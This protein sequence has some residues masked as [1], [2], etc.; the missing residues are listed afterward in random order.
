MWAVGLQKELKKA[1]KTFS[2]LELTTSDMADFGSVLKT[3]G[4]NLVI[5]NTDKFAFVSPFLNSLRTA[6]TQYD[7]LLFEQYSW[8]NQN[9]KMPEGIYI[10][11]F[12]FNVNQDKL[13][14]YN[15]FVYEL[16][17]EKFK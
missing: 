4:K 12:I 7:L 3:D 13:N 5:F 1:N 8:K 11:P 14:A 6:A 10:S 17:W 16:L 9:E 2:K 15:S